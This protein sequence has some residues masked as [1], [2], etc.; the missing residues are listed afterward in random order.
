M[1]R[2]RY[3]Q[4]EEGKLIPAEEYHNPSMGTHFIQGDIKPYKSMIDG[5]IIEGRKQHR[6]HLKDNGCIEIGNETVKPKPL[7]PPQ[8]LKQTLI[9]VV[10]SKLRY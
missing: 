6:T 2:Q 7:T 4:N 3:I 1:T 9:E 8:G 5:S 10:N